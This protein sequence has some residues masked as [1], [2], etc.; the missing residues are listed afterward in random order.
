[1]TFIVFAFDNL[2]DIVELNA[3]SDKLH[4][5]LAAKIGGPKGPDSCPP[6][7]YTQAL[8]RVFSA[9][10]RSSFNAFAKPASI[11]GRMFAELKIVTDVGCQ[12]MARRRSSAR[13]DGILVAL[14]PQHRTQDRAVK[15]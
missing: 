3:S 4:G 1:M 13:F 9:L 15:Y 7:P 2:R 10:R 6:T 8:R 5:H 14:D 12:S 11:H